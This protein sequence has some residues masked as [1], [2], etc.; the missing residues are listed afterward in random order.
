KRQENRAYSGSRWADS[1]HFCKLR[2]TGRVNLDRALFRFRS[3]ARGLVECLD[4]ILKKVVGI[5][6]ACREPE[7]S[8]GD[9]EF[10]TCLVRQVLVRRRSRM[11]DEALRITEIVGDLR[12]LERVLQSECCLL[13]ALQFQ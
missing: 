2:I 4:E 12:D 10:G 5:L 7:R 9:A 6:D 11:G 3:S 8:G 13:A 1:V